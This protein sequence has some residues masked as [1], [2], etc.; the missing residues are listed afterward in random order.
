MGR[1]RARLARFGND[2]SA[3]A[4]LEQQAVAIL[5]LQRQVDTLPAELDA[6]R[7]ELRRVVDD[8]ATRIDRI[9]ERLDALENGSR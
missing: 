3:R 1:V 8:L 2:E 7:D 5:A 9:S 6:M 4:D